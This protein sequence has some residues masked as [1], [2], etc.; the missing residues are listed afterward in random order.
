MI[1]LI[2]GE[3]VPCVQNSMRQYP[4]YN[5]H[6]SL[7]VRIKE[8][9]T[10]KNQSWSKLELDKDVDLN[11]QC[12]YL[13]LLPKINSLCQLTISAVYFHRHVAFSSGQESDCILTLL[14]LV[15]SSVNITIGLLIWFSKKDEI[16]S[17]YWGKLLLGI[18]TLFLAVWMWVDIVLDISMNIRYHDQS[19]EWNQQLSNTSNICNLTTLEAEWEKVED[20]FKPFDTISPHNCSLAL[21]GYYFAAGLPCLLLPPVIFGTLFVSLKTA[22]LKQVRCFGKVHCRGCNSNSSKFTWK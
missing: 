11:T 2:I 10:D 15:V 12:T 6:L 22:D 14:I 20:I 18:L 7:A 3:R 13:S 17:S 21:E 1:V 9:P 19:P 16:M 5:Q 4:N 8:E